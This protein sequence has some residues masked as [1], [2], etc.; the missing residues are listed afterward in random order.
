MGGGSDI[1]IQVSIRIMNAFVAMRRALA[2]VAPL[3][4]RIEAADRRRGGEKCRSAEVVPQGL[5]PGM[6]ARGRHD[7][8][9]DKEEVAPPCGRAGRATLPSVHGLYLLVGLRCPLPRVTSISQI[10]PSCGSCQVLACPW[11]P[12][13]TMKS[14]K[15]CRR[16][17][18]C[19]T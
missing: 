18:G 4:A 1:A 14:T 2:S 16:T 3:L 5:C 6:Q 11:T 15:F 9:A 17:G 10:F 12:W 19:G 7:R 13:T 8:L